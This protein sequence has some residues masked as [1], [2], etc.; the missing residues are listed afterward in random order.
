MSRMVGP[1]PGAA[2]AAQDGA[3]PGVAET[4]LEWTKSALIGFVL[5]LFIRAFLI[6][7]FTIVSGSMEGT[8]LVGDFLLLSKSAFGA[9]VPG[10]GITLPGYDEPELRDI[11]V[12]HRQEATDALVKRIVGMPGDTLAMADGVLFRNGE[13]QEEPYALR[14]HPG[15]DAWDPAMRWQLAYRVDASDDPDSPSRENWGPIAVPEGHYFVMGDNRHN[16]FDSRHWGFVPRESIRGRVVALYFSVRYG[17]MEGGM[18]VLGRVRWDRIGR[19][20]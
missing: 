7:T 13:P 12:F 11:V 3:E 1:H 19:L 17:R 16:S 9:T 20:H 8:L 18:P 6:Q 10:T 5:F 2:R 14:T 15:S 4:A